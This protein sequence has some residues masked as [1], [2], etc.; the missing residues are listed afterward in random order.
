M[1]QE[2]RVLQVLVVELELR[3][4]KEPQGMQP[5]V[6]K[7]LLVLRVHQELMQVKVLRVLLV[8]LVLRVLQELQEQCLPL[9]LECYSNKHQHQADGQR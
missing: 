9:E 1:E 5:L 6:L 8:L 3:V 4:L 2:H 7:V